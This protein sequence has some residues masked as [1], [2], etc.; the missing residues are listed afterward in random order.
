MQ[1]AVLLLGVFGVETLEVEGKN[2]LL[3]MA[4]QFRLFLSVEPHH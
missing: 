2:N 3:E 4:V 1:P